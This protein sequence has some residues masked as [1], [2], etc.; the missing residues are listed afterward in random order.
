MVT[1]QSR[2]IY[3]YGS[4]PLLRLKVKD[5]LDRPLT[6]CDLSVIRPRQLL[7]ECPWFA[8][9]CLCALQVLLKDAYSLIL[10]SRLGSPK[11]PLMLHTFRRR[12]TRA[13]HKGAFRI[14]IAD[15]DTALASHVVSSV[16][17]SWSMFLIISARANFKV[18]P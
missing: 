6:R 4:H 11:S 1:L 5:K 10:A 14:R 17:C 13:I 12:F 16:R 18:P 2:Y 15:T 8:S 9:C 7:P 3:H